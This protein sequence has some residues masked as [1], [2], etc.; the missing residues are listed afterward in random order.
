MEKYIFCRKEKV[1]NSI[2]EREK[3]KRIESAVFEIS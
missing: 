2:Y 1:E 3:K